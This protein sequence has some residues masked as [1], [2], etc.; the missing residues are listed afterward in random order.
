MPGWNTRVPSRP[1]DPP[2]CHPAMRPAA[3]SILRASCRT[4]I[5]EDQLTE[6]LACV[7]SVNTTFAETLVRLGRGRPGERYEV[8][9][10]QLTPSGRRVDMQIAS[11]EDDRRVGLMYVEDKE[12]AKY[13]RNQLPGYATDVR[14]PVF[15]DRGGRVLTIIPAGHEQVED[16]RPRADG[17]RWKTATWQ[18]IAK[19]ADAVGRKWASGSTNGHWRKAALRPDA[20][21]QWRYLAEL[22]I[23]LE[24]RSLARM[25]PLTPEDVIVA[26][27]AG[28]FSKSIEKLVDD[29]IE[30]T[31]G[32]TLEAK[33]RWSG[34]T[35][36]GKL[37]LDPSKPY[38]ATEDP[39]FRPHELQYV[40][41]DRDDEFDAP[42]FWIGLYFDDVSEE[43][44]VVLSDRDWQSRLAKKGLRVVATN[45]HYL[46]R[47]KYLSELVV[48]RTF[49]DQT[50]ALAAWAKQAI[51]EIKAL[52]APPAPAPTP[53]RP[54]GTR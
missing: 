43:G 28:A 29:A 17:P 3:T 10:Q 38:W 13:E 14:H 26:Q 5:R 33:P 9:T 52:S 19:L 48:F 15:G 12:W 2:V 20:P 53:G 44:H 16:N 11:Y 1:S 24:E 35:L 47:W 42:A 21:A 36:T 46:G 34:Q 27:R 31:P 50:R 41:Q 32:I 51:D 23:H 39:R 49:D 4:S 6:V 7:A 37:Q 8:G 54:S 40:Y 30:A 25:E 18:D 22:I 45:Y